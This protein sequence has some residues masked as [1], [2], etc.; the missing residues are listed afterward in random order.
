MTFARGSVPESHIALWPFALSQMVLVELA[1]YKQHLPSALFA[2]ALT[3]SLILPSFWS[4]WLA[5]SWAALL[6]GLILTRHSWGSKAIA[7]SLVAMLALVF[8]AVPGSLFIGSG[9]WVLTLG[10]AIW[11]APA[12][13]FYWADLD[14][15]VFAWLVP[16]WVIHSGLITLQAFSGSVR[17]QT[18]GYPA[19]TPTGLALNSNL[20]AGFLVLGVVYL[21]ALDTRWRWLA[22]PLLVVLPLTG[23]RWAVIV[24]VV[25]AGGMAL[26][27]RTDW[28]PVAAALLIW[29]VA[30]WGLS[31]VAPE[32]E[33]AMSGFNNMGA[34]IAPISNGQISS[35]L[36]VPHIPSI[37][38]RGVAEHPGL[39]NVPLRIAVENGIIAAV[40]WVGVTGWA[41]VRAPRM[42]I[43]WWMLLA[44]ALLSLL[45]YYSWMGHLG[46]FWWLLVG[47]RLKQRQGATA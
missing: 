37:L 47:M 21:L 36:A 44:L 8:L 16:V 39:H 29:G 27:R 6:G 35:R 43:A 24:V 9:N 18:P 34:V 12:I 17:M 33:Y 19:L 15:R 26:T 14:S 23:S 41:L 30:A 25:L 5:I 2:L 4:P 28:K 31:L 22:V 11:M 45:D 38:P 1:E 42:D 20:A 3:S 32:S 7:A 13:G 46:G 40:L 10:V